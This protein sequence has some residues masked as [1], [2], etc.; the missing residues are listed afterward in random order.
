MI[1][2]LGDIPQIL[3]IPTSLIA[4]I[5]LIGLK[6]LY[7]DPEKK[8]RRQ[9]KLGLLYRNNKI[10]VFEHGVMA[11]TPEKRKSIIPWEMLGGWWKQNWLFTFLK[12]IKHTMS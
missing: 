7:S 9:L 8:I 12:R 5:A 6:I 3:T 11:G 1:W 4:L 10:S 2:S